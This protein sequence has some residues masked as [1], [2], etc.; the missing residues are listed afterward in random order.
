MRTAL[1]ESH[2]TPTAQVKGL[3]EYDTTT[4][5]PKKG[6]SSMLKAMRGLSRGVVVA[7]N[8]QHGLHSSA[9]VGNP[10][11]GRLTSFE[12]QPIPPVKSPHRESDTCEKMC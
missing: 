11:S 9:T 3:E 5:W 12:A 8:L 2:H 7:L 10:A 4:L 1:R 6:T